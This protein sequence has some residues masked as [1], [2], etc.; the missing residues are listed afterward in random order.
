MTHQHHQNHDHSAGHDGALTGPHAMLE[1]QITN[2]MMASACPHVEH[3]LGQ[4]PGVHHAALNRTSGVIEVGYNPVQTSPDAIIEAVKQCG[5]VCQE[6]GPVHQAGHVPAEHTD[7]GGHAE[8]EGHDAHAGHG[9]HM[10][11]TMRNLFFV[12]AAISVVIILYSPLGTRL[13]GLNLP[14]P[15]GI[16]TGLWQF[17]LT[18]PVVFIGGRPFLSVAW[19]A[20]LKGQLN[21]ATLIA[22]GILTAYLYSVGATFVFS[23]D[24]FY[25]AA[26][27]LT[28]FSLLGHWMEMAARNAT[29]E[30][31]S[32]LLKLAPATARVLRDGAEVEVPV[33]EVQPGDIIAVRPGEKVPVDGEVIEGQSY[34]DESMITGEPV[35][36]EKKAGAKVT[37]AT[38]NTTGAFRFKA[39]H[40]GADTALARIVQMVQSAQGSKAP[41]QR[42]ADE[43]GKYLVFVAL[44][45][46]ALALFV[47]LVL[48]ADPIF[49]LTVAV[50]T[51]VI[52]CP[53]ALALATPTAI[54]VGMGMGAGNGVLIKDAT[55]LEGVATLDTIVMD[56]TGTLTEGKPS[57]TDVITTAQLTE[58]ALLARVAALEKDSEHPLAQAIVR[59]VAERGLSP[60]RNITGFETVPGHG[61][62]AQVDGNRLAI[63]NAKM[64][65]R[66]GAAVAEVQ[67]EVNRL[68][69]EGKTV[70][71]VAADGK[72][73]G[74]IA[75]ADKPK[76]T[77]AET[78]RALHGLGLQV[79]MLT[80]DARRTAEAVAA[81]L[82]I[83]T[84]I[85]EVLPEQK[86]DK[87]AE[88][89]TQQQRVAMVGDGVN[90]AP[91]LAT[92][93]VGIAI[94][95]GTDVAI[96][97]ADVVLMRSDPFDIVKAISLARKVRGKIKQNL[98]WAA[99]YNII[100][101]PIAAGILYSSLGI[102]L[103]PEWAAL[104]MAASTITVTINALALKWAGLPH[105][106]TAVVAPQTPAPV[107]VA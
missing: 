47:W 24:V 49:A 87:V 4:T 17:L 25:E 48:G 22:T 52:A 55:A 96:D 12:S 40:V 33:E 80:G 45:S 58:E 71:Y 76:A 93:D 59:S 34:V 35:P 46:G 8:H 81:T 105:A 75:L 6:G 86:A 29:G 82:G 103:R 38:L 85:A 68:S 14:T 36:V 64:M 31:I 100:A 101:I 104:A 69:S 51:V 20:L 2:Y 13:L 5:F 74:L 65:A 7:H 84:V 107:A 15:L 23:G 3:H 19:K 44:G 98:F 16:S 53:D 91:A 63:G 61:A 43:A 106:E 79:A 54:T 88:L 95:A 18:T 92:A 39:E 62:L 1:L 56:K 89:Q 66:E 70:T 50:S 77:A 73:A 67:P 83:D 10:A 41:A 94:G 26:A 9:A 60:A 28:T 42:L 30:A 90:D 72:L 27:M 37:G 11:T 102:L 21:M 78:V 32:S 97:T 99:V 57:V